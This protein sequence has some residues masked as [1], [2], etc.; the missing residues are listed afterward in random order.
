MMSGFGRHV[1][2]IRKH[3][4]L[5]MRTVAEEPPARQKYRAAN[6]VAGRSAEIVYD[7]GT[8]MVNG[9]IPIKY[10]ADPR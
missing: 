6:G 1:N 8:E 7:E 4:L 9:L 2:D 10:A 3:K 5:G